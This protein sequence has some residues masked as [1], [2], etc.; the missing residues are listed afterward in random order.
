MMKLLK[1]AGIA[2]ALVT[3]ALASG[4]A[5]RDSVEVD[6]VL[7]NVATVSHTTTGSGAP[8][9]TSS[10]YAE[11]AIMNVGPVGL[12]SIG[13]GPNISTSAYAEAAFINVGRGPR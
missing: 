1:I 11:Q 4:A 3:F 8:N 6:Q 7:M 13:G 2:V 9:V 12:G 10:P 5:A